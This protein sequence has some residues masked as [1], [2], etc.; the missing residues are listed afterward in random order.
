MQIKADLHIH[1]RFSRATSAK[2]SPAY[3]DRWARIKG[4]D[5][6]G[7]GDCT[8]PLWLAE[9]REQL[10]DA[11]EGCY[12]LKERLRKDFDTGPGLTEGLPDP[13]RAGE[14]PRFVLSGEISTIYKR[15]DRTRKIHHLTLLPDFKAAAALQTRLERVGNI[16]S[17]GRPILGIDSRD[18][19]ALILDADERALLIPAHIWTPWFSA[20][21]AK[22][23]FD[24]IDEC[25][26]DLASRI[27]AIETGLSSNPP[28]NWA[29][30]ALDRFAVISNSDAHSPDKLGREGTVFEMERSFP[31]LIAA[32]R[33]GGSAGPGP[34][35]PGPKIVET[36]EFFPQEGKYHY[37][38]H[39]NCGVYRGPGEAADGICP[40]CKK[41]LTRGVMGRVL[42]LAERPVDEHAPYAADGGFP[43]R[44]PYRS[45]VPLKEILGELLQ[46]GP[47]SKKVLSAYNSLIGQ[48]GS[49]LAILMDMDAAGLAGLRCPGLSGELLAGALGRMRTGEVFI[50]PGYDGEYGVIRVV[51]GAPAKRNAASVKRGQGALLWEAAEAV[52]HAPQSSGESPPPPP[53]KFSLEAA[54]EAAAAYNGPEALI[55]AGPGTGK[56][57]V[58]AA[59]IARLL[60]DGTDPASILAITFTVKAAQELR[61]RISAAAGDGGA[62]ITAATFH[63][64]CAALLREQPAAASGGFR[65]L[66]A[67]ERESLL[68]ETLAGV[69]RKGGPTVRRLEEYIE[70]RK[71]FLLLPG[72]TR[73]GVLAP[74]AEELGLPPMEADMEEWYGGYQNRLRGQGLWDFEDLLSGAAR[75]LMQN[76]PLLAEY[77]ARFRRILVD[78]Y[79]DVNFA[80]YALIRLLAPGSSPAS[81]DGDSAQELR[82]IG[83]PNQ[84]IYA[85]RG[86]DKRFIDRFREDYPGAARL[87]LTR[88][89]RCAAPII[90]AAGE[91]AA[92]PLQGAEDAEA[93][94]FR[95]PYP[96]ERAE[97][98]GIARRIAA[99]VGGTSFL[100]MDRGAAVGDA[101]LGDCAIL[102]RTLALAPPIA[103]ALGDFGIPFDLAGEKPWWEEEPAAAIL[104]RI[105]EHYGGAGGRESAVQWP[106]L[107]SIKAID[108]S[109][110]AAKPRKGPANGDSLD[111]LRAL[112]AIYEDPRALADILAMSGM[113][114]RGVD[115]AR[116]GVR[117]MS[118][119]ASK[120]LEFDHVF[121]PAL[122]EGLLPFTLYDAAADLPARIGEEKRLLYVAMTRA[123]RGL[124]L[125]W[126]AARNFRGRP[127][128]GGPSRFLQGLEALI[129]LA[130][131]RPPRKRDSQ[132]TLF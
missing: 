74:L 89:F 124:Y 36:I 43:N 79:Q 86:S 16:R 88:S 70:G 35:G 108:E 110:N 61:E 23:G 100:A 73:P 10:E 2:L 62:G 42:E 76:P 84:A 29:V 14:P 5:L 68:A 80:Q 105:R 114:E 3:L 21:G 47:D 41:P 49:E 50:T 98:E 32:L 78:E 121:V 77:R 129:P 9:L 95:A 113:E 71:R 132:L 67:A 69:P 20:L 7:T 53:R 19:L 82:V 130:K 60:R 75:L 91:L 39:R 51:S 40:V 12:T 30:P 102:L 109:L 128:T 31:S 106:P 13:G 112:A 37:D 48:A 6:L 115:I 26:G 72:E 8:H 103:K 117:I 116:E 66:T 127:L 123:R 65:V 118:I 59:R 96:T 131:E 11:G 120:G 57:A 94:L 33:S 38:G 63:S 27:P 25:Y 58:L 1:S 119:H 99:L 15:G 81:P 126:A 54:Q 93:L 83:D 92:A 64:F 101:A 24:S 46:T 28:M 52:I 17:D 111:R 107:S 56:T 55:I 104:A 125:S 90:R 122:E 97:A 85:F 45:L 44:R 87:E 34:G 22:S 18:L 4:L